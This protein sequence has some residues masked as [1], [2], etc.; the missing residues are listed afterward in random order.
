MPH[1]EIVSIDEPYNRLL[2][3]QFRNE[4][5]SRD[6]LIPNGGLGIG[7]GSF[8]CGSGDETRSYNSLV[9]GTASSNPN[10]GDEN[11]GHYKIVR[12]TDQCRLETGCGQLV[13]DNKSFLMGPP[14]YATNC[15]PLGRSHFGES[16]V[17]VLS[18]EWN[19]RNLIDD[20]YGF[21]Y[22]RYLF[23]QLESNTS[24][25]TTARNALSIHT[26]R[27]HPHQMGAALTSVNHLD[28]P[29]SRQHQRWGFVCAEGCRA[30]GY[31]PG[32][33]VSCERFSSGS[34]GRVDNE[35][36]THHRIL[37]ENVIGRLGEMIA[38]G[39]FGDQREARETVVTIWNI[40]QEMKDQTVWGHR[41]GFGMI[42]DRVANR[43]KIEISRCRNLPRDALMEYKA[44]EKKL[45]IR[46]TIA[47]DCQAK[48]AKGSRANHNVSGDWAD[49]H[50][51]ASYGTWRGGGLWERGWG[52]VQGYDVYP[53]TRTSTNSSGRTTTES[54]LQ[55]SEGGW[56]PSDGHSPVIS[57]LMAHQW[58]HIFYQ[59]RLHNN[60]MLLWP[61]D[62]EALLEEELAVMAQ[63]IVLSIL[64]DL[65]F[66]P[67]NFGIEQQDFVSEVTATAG[68]VT[69]GSSGT[70]VFFSNT[71]QGFGNVYLGPLFVNSR[72]IFELLKQRKVELARML[73]VYHSMAHKLPY[74]DQMCLNG[75]CGAFN[76]PIPPARGPGLSDPS[77]STIMRERVQR[78]K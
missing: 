42:A 11:R 41:S 33:S 70:R 58:V 77:S 60:R 10:L 17:L 2:T 15:H 23:G 71:P 29:Y 78:R 53:V 9:G 69:G 27:D 1:S 57:A 28:V 36:L 52:T 34:D 22:G 67:I 8:F 66:A 74:P 47:G 24:E 54:Y 6:T 62:H 75:T 63:S 38:N 31:G 32:S 3:P 43:D 21:L 39:N 68:R 72:N 13:P 35:F 76:L 18:L 16:P 44:E 51:Y 50:C 65:D 19:R 4:L 46:S 45:C 7:V 73:A 5:I 59:R 56:R 61:Q 40:L 48:R 64:Q 20:D 12:L 55:S 37:L 30:N 49:G 14:L 25:L 26:D